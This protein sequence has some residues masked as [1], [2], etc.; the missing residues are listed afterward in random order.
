MMSAGR[1]SAFAATMACADSIGLERWCSSR[2]KVEFYNLKVCHHSSQNSL[3]LCAEGD[4]S[5]PNSP[6]AQ[7]AGYTLFI[8][9]TV[10]PSGIIWAYGCVRE[11]GQKSMPQSS[12]PASFPYLAS[13]QLAASSV[14][15]GKCHKHALAHTCTHAHTHT[16]L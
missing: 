7:C 9:H 14:N 3:C 11:P 12:K 16:N 6:L 2:C 13:R 1:A 15:S 10:H 5:P 4:N 8:T